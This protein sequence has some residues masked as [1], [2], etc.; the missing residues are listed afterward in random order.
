[1]SLYR[2]LHGEFESAVQMNPN[3]VKISIF[4]N[5]YKKLDFYKKK[6]NTFEIHI[7]YIKNT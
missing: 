4:T 2:V 5:F 1:M 7:K 6:K 3:I